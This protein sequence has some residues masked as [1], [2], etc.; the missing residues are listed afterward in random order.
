MAV[1]FF[2]SPERPCIRS[3]ASSGEK[4]KKRSSYQGHLATEDIKHLW[5]FST[6]LKICPLHTHLSPLYQQIFQNAERSSQNIQNIFPHLYL[7]ITMLSIYKWPQNSQTYFLK[8]F[9]LLM[10]AS[11]S[12]QNGLRTNFSRAL[13]KKV[14]VLLFIESVLRTEKHS[15]EFCDFSLILQENTFP[16]LERTTMRESVKN[17]HNNSSH[18]ITSSSARY[19]VLTLCISS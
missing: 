11:K 6:N 8:R 10:G 1:F 3:P 18:V 2:S 12:W 17:H 19:S 9:T 7:P 15:H 13:L 5:V 14:R 16:E 4:K